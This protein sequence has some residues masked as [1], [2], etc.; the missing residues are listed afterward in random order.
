[1]DVFEKSDNV[2]KRALTLAN[3][4]KA[5]LF[6]VYV[7]QLP[8]LDIPSY[9]SSKEI[10]IDKK[11]INKKIEK[12]IKTLNTDSKVPCYVSIKEGDTD[13][14]ILNESKLHKA[15]MIIIG[16]HSKAKGKKRFLGTTA[17]KIA[18]KSHLPIL[19]VKD[20][21]KRQ[22]QNIIAPTDFQTQSKQSILFAKN[23]FPY[24]KINIV[25]ASETIYTE[26]PYTLVDRN[27]KHY[28]EVAK[29]CAEKDLKDFMQDVYVEKGKIIGGGSDNKEALLKYIKKGS[30][31]L[32]VVGSRGTAG[33]H[34][35]LGSFA[36]YLLRES[37]TDVLV[38]VPIG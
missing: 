19:I 12:K 29:A 35:L 10:G 20:D 13:D 2:L 15:D 11:T 5:E 37:E 6:V 25:H 18:H 9:F 33:L 14:A 32:V 8:W 7:V 27:N 34:A 38:Y 17:Q 28:N 22:Y 30:Y 1:M 24:S 16:A 21:A 26:G 36:S 23:I 31:D 4:H 3:E